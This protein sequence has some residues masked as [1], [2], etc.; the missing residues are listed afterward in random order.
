MLKRKIIYGTPLRD[1]EAQKK[2]INLTGLVVDSMTQNAYI[3]LE[4]GNI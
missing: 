1:Y 3:T 2:I 4:N